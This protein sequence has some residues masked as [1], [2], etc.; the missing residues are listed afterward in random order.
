MSFPI[1]FA[2]QF[3]KVPGRLLQ[4]RLKK[5]SDMSLA[6]NIHAPGICWKAAICLM[7][8]FM[9]LFIDSFIIS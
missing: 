5:Q 7:A 8:E 9:V 2:Q 1:D 4:A 6:G 3:P